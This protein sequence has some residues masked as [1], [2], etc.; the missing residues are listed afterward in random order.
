MCTCQITSFDHIVNYHNFVSYLEQYTYIAA[1]VVFSYMS[2][3]EG[4][5][6]YDF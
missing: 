5:A 6:K 2:R 3:G 4:E 1:E